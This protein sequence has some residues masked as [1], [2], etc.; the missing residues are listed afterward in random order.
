MFY[1]ETNLLNKN[2]I[3]M[4]EDLNQNLMES[5]AKRLKED[6]LD[7]FLDWCKNMDIYINYDK[8]SRFYRV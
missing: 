3:I 8:V 2:N 6:D 1:F 7:R 5:K 4:E